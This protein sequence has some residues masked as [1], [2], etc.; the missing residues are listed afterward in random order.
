MC[1]A[2]QSSWAEAG[3][4]ALAAAASGPTTIGDKLLHLAGNL[5]FLTG[6]LAAA[7]ARRRGALPRG[8]L[9]RGR[10]TLLRAALWVQGLHVAEHL[11]LTTTLIL[12]GRGHGVSTGFGLFASGTTAAIAWRV[13]LH[14]LIN[15]VATVLAVSALANWASSARVVHQS[16]PLVRQTTA[17]PR[18]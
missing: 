16:G 17:A 13:W 2:V 12:A 5:A 1:H 11:A 18:G 8:A 15:L 7:A 14:F 3:R 6:L 10:Q 4:D 9:P